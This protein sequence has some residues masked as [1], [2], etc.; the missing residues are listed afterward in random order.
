EKGRE[1]EFA[2]LIKGLHP[3]DVAEL[4][5]FLEGHDKVRFYFLLDPKLAA[6]VLLSLPE[7]SREHL[8]SILPVKLLSR[9]VDEM[10]SDDGTD[11]VA[12]LSDEDASSILATIDVEDS[13]EI[14]RL[15]K[16]REDTAGGLMQLELVVAGENETVAE[17]IEHIRAK[18]HEVQDLNYVFVV[19]EN[20]KLLGQV[21][22]QTLVL[23]SP[24]TRLREVVSPV[25]LIINVDEDQEEVARKFMKY[26][27]RAAPVVSDKGILLGRITVDD[28]IDVVQEEASEDFYR[29]AGTH[30]DE[31]L[32]QSHVFKIVKLRLPWLLVNLLGGFLSGNL[33]WLFKVTLKDVLVLVAFIPIIT[34]LGG[35]VGIQSSTIVIRGLA[36]GRFGRGQVLRIL[37]RDLRVALALGLVCGSGAALAAGLWQSTAILGL[38]VGLSMFLAITLAGT[39]GSLTPLILKRLNIDPA[40]ASGPFTTAMNDITGLTIYMI[41]ATAFLRIFG[42]SGMR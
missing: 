11:I 25:E 32:Y 10:D 15:L 35:S 7:H 13:D 26:D 24:D 31:E 17:A 41:I 2:R 40:L 4:M 36:L 23:S 27:T 28:V 12:S 37:A 6:E 1:E 22:L 39:L 14:S 19:D 3:A 8:L 30:E 21:D 20:H 29:V 16:Y 34:A 38:V 33:I 5:E 42:L 18:Q 9:A